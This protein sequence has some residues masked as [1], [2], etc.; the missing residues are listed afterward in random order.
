MNKTERFNINLSCLVSFRHSHK[1]TDR[2][3]QISSLSPSLGSNYVS[4][5]ANK[6]H[7]LMGED[8]ALTSQEK[9][10]ARVLKPHWLQT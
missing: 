9:Q 6:E 2:F 4:T 3:C 7:G 10:G 1:E 8:G 5:N